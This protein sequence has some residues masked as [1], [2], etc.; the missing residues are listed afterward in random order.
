MY[1]KSRKI[2]GDAVRLKSALEEQLRRSH[3][4]WLRVPRR[5]TRGLTVTNDENHVD[6]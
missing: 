1:A 2:M 6:F 5:R 4:V 3:D